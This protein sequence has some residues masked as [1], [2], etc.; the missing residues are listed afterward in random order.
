[1]A[2]DY[3]EKIQY[4]PLKILLAKH[5][6]MIGQIPYFLLD[7][8]RSLSHPQ[9]ATWGTSAFFIFTKALDAFSIDFITC[10]PKSIKYDGTHDRIL[11]IVNKLWKMYHWISFCTDM[12]IKNLAKMIK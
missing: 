7:L 12:T 2:L 11:E 10:L 1:M 5:L 4:I 8:S 3:Q 9:E 6:Q